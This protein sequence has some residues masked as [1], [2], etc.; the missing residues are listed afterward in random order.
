MHSDWTG[1]KLPQS[2]IRH[3]AILQRSAQELDPRELGTSSQSETEKIGGV[4]QKN[5]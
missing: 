3:K 4:K 5:R 2:P 1:N